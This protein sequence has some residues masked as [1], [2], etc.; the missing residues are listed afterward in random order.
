[1]NKTRSF[2]Q[3][4]ISQKYMVIA[5]LA[6]GAILLSLVV[7]LDRFYETL[8]AR[9]RSE[10]QH[11]VEQAASM[12]QGFVAEYQSG[13]LSKEEARRRAFNALRPMRFDTNGYIFAV[14]F[15]GVM[16]LNPASPNL[17]GSNTLNT[18]DANG[19]EFFREMVAIGNAG[20][21]GF[22]DYTWPRPGR[23]EAVSKAA[24]LIPIKDFDVIVGSG[25]YL[26]DAAAQIWK[27]IERI[28]LLMIP[29][30]G[31]FVLYV[32]RAG[33]ASSKRLGEMTRAM[34]DLAGGNFSVVLPGLDRPDEIGDMARAVEEF[35]IK[36][37]DEAARVAQEKAARDQEAAAQRRQEMLTLASQFE[38]AVG[39]IVGSVSTSANKLDVV[40]RSMA[41]NAHQAEE[42]AQT[43]ADAAV[44]TSNNV[45]S[46]AA[47]TEQ[48]SQ[49]IKEIGQQAERSQK[50]SAESATEAARA[51]QQVA[52]LSSAVD[53]I[54]G[55]VT[56]ISSVAEQTNMLAL[57]ATIEAARAGE[58]GRGF[59][60]VAQEVKS[61]A[62]QTAK[63]TEEI[64]AQIAGVQSST[65]ETSKFIAAI[66]ETTQEVNS[67]ACVIAGT[68]EAQDSAAQEIAQNVLQASER[69]SQLKAAVEDVRSVSQASGSAAEEVLQSIAEL[70]RQT[71]S[72]RSECDRFLNHVR[73]A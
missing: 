18:K 33:R 14:G 58:A 72:L 56:M 55:I 17:E 36:A 45:Q 50:I 30:L 32:V 37:A 68:L 12:V 38:K 40:A 6:V 19:R 67:I 66:A 28:G 51:I 13:A 73:S 41:A 49:S 48:L 27:V 54:G 43:G 65:N 64:A 24:Y 11:E 61:L 1:M 53:R 5:A 35:K 26:D 16:A 63:A 9:S 42:E 34:D 29:I 71:V 60:V 52:D 70:S 4:T 39:G 22:V 20:R 46:V 7:A 44:M 69:T 25:I 21:S 57:N 10:I 2:L 62:E 47:A 15:D 8:E 23:S 3:P 59:A 31:L